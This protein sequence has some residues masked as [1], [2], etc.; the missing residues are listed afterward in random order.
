MKNPPASTGKKI[1]GGVFFRFRIAVPAN[2]FKRI[3]C[4]NKSDFP[5]ALRFHGTSID[6]P[7]F[8]SFA[9]ELHT[10][11]CRSTKQ[12]TN[13][14]SQRDSTVSRICEQMKEVVRIRES[15]AF[16]SGII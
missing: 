13:L 9:I 15:V 2:T 10:Y 7:N 8:K 14:H 3:V 4:S 1:T 16:D 12:K 6:Q 5:I 11:T